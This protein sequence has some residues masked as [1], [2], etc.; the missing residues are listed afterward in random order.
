MFNADFR[1]PSAPAAP[2]FSVESNDRAV[3]IVW[4]YAPDAVY[5]GFAG[6]S[7]FEGFRIWR[8]PDGFNFALVAEFDTPGNGIGYDLG[9]PEET[10]E[11]SDIPGLYHYAYW[12]GGLANGFPLYYAVTA[13]DDGDNGDGFQHPAIDE[14]L[15]MIGIL[16]SSRGSDQ[17]QY[18]VPAKTVAAEGDL[19]DVFVVPNPYIGGSQLEEV[20]AWFGATRIYPK[21]IEFRKLPGE[22]EI[23]IFSLG[24]DLVQEINH[25]SGT[26]W[27][28]WDLRTTLDQEIAGGIYFYRV[29]SGGES[30]IGKFVVVK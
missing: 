28:K 6:K 7:D 18:V 25:D 29:E 10:S 1:G 17:Q 26:S 20:P 23:K 24:G 30:T 13:F 5:D 16:E 22:C 15:G 3:R 27:E 21:V 11:D 2:L 9:W 14:Q 4:E 8:T 12:D 19:E